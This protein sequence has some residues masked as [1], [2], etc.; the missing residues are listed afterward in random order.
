MKRTA[1]RVAVAVTALISAVALTA[2]SAQAAAP[3]SSIQKGALRSGLL[4]AWQDPGLNGRTCWWFNA[5][6]NWDNIAGDYDLNACSDGSRA[7]FRNQ[8]SSVWN[9]GNSGR[10]VNLYYHTGYT[11]AWMCL[12]VGDS[13]DDLSQQWFSWGS[14]RDGYHASG[15]NN[16]ASHR[17]VSSCGVS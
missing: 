12:G 6:T 10:P 14:G 9:D 7:S 3:Q 2:T 5:S 4:Y 17:W 8:A 11:G 15:D 1:I 13:F 16:I